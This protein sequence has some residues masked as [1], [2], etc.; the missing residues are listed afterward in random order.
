MNICEFLGSKKDID[1]K[2]LLIGIIGVLVSLKNRSI[3]ID[4]SE[5]FLFSP[6]NIR[7]LTNLN[8]DTSILDLI[9]NGC[10]LENFESLMP[11]KLNSEIDYMIQE[12]LSLLSDYSQYDR[13]HWIEFP[14]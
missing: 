10:L 2:I 11:K 13:E 9:E 14:K 4:E 8:C 12:A 1:E 7:L 3:T 6:R 5:S